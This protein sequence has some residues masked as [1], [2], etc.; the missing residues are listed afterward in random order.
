VTNDWI[1]DVIADLRSFAVKN[2]LD[3]LAYSLERAIDVAHRDLTISP[4]AT[5][6]RR[7]ADVSPA[8]TDLRPRSKSEHA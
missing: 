3:E 4:S 1:L 2:G 8:R 6:E 7:A 5:T